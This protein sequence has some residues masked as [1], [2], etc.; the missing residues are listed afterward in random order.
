ML[1][2]KYS[3]PYT[4]TLPAS[5]NNELTVENVF[6]YKEKKANNT[7]EI[8]AFFNMKKILGNMAEKY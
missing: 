3:P 1:S 5:S 6:A 8:A 4:S 2:K 7:Q